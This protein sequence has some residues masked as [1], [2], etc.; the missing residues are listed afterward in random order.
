MKATTVSRP[1]LFLIELSLFGTFLVGTVLPG[2]VLAQSAVPTGAGDKLFQQYCSSCHGADGRGNGPVA[3]Q[4]RATV[5]DL[6]LIAARRNGT[7]PESEIAAFIDG[8]S[9]TAAHGSREMPVWGRNFSAQFGGG[10]I[11]EEAT[12]GYLTALI[13][14]LKSIQK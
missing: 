13:A 7:F 11:S 12:R 14:Y 10:E 4:L 5:P 6:Q 1:S 2:S 9:A 8:R 3:S